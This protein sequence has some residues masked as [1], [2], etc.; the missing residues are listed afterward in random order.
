MID[1]DILKEAGTTNERLK[2]LFTAKLPGLRKLNKLTPEKRK[3]LE[4][5]IE[6]RKKFEEQLASWIQ[7][8][9]VF[10][11]KNHSLYS[12]VD[13][14]WDSVLN[15]HI[16]PL[17]L[18][19]QGR[20][21]VKA[22][23]TGLKDLPEGNTYVR[24]NEKGDVVGIDLPKFFDVRI[25]LIR[26][27]ITRRLAAQSN[28]FNNLWPFL[29]YESRSTGLVGRIKADAVSQRVDIMADQYGFRHLQ[30][31]MTRDMFL[32]GHSVALPR[33]AWEREVQWEKI[34]SAE[35]VRSA[36]GKIPKRS[37]VI[38]EGVCPVN[39]HPSRIG[40]DN[41]YPLSSL[42]TDTGCE[43]VFFWDVKRFKDIECEK[44][45]FNR[46][47][48]AFSADTAGWFSTYSTY[49]NQYYDTITPPSIPKDPAQD[50]DRKTN[51]GLYTGEM[52]DSAVFVTEFYVKVRPDKWR[53][54][55]YPFPIWLHLTV[56]GDATVINAEIMPSSPAFVF[57]FNENDSRLTNISVAH[58]LMAYQDQLTNLFTQFLEA[59]KADMFAVAVLNEDVFGDT[60]EGQKVLNEFKAI[61][62][63]KNYYSSMQVLTASFAKLAQVGVNVS[64][65]NIFK[66]VRSTPNTAI[67]KIFQSITEVIAMAERLMAL[68]PQEQGQ[69][70]PRE[71]SAT[72]TNALTNTTDSVYS[73]I[74]EP[75]D[76]GRAAWKR[77]CYESLVAMG[78]DSV[79]LPILNRYP[80]SAIERAGFKVV[81]KDE[82]EPTQLSV[83]VT[84][85]KTALI[86]DYIFTSRDGGERASNAQ[87]AQVLVELL[88]AIGQ[89][90]PEVQ[91]AILKSMGKSK[92]LDIINE[93]FR[94]ADAGLDLNLEL[95]PGDDDNLLM[96]DDQQV[97]G[98]I[99]RLGQAL[100]KES[101]R[102][103]AL[104]QAVMEMK[105]LLTGAPPQEAAA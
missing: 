21:D 24:K 9:V 1:L 89:F 93:I 88:R 45:Y 79:Y 67:D 92:V 61:M 72:E 84:G 15:K 87:Q 78:S 12:A 43:H 55:S 76:E 81:G 60:D 80:D 104:E 33:T 34:P 86:H 27:I 101:E 4:K 50:N 2:E 99:N 17:V 56:A 62:S 39:P 6:T 49:F 26:S 85:S 83:N 22:C 48:I 53:M 102:T 30:T 77:I 73:F 57:S 71:I 38:R 37:R 44:S 91:K 63:G 35:G 51:V 82:E 105:Q 25:N 19:A 46:D 36:D 70:A 66:I 74:S 20:I 75:I 13:L 42:N 28:K 96:E 10:S 18:Y 40:Y 23:A 5:D 90:Q 32:Y 3:D 103:A 95:Q 8:Q 7:E 41:S 47:G 94:K 65:D 68:S 52:G 16:L 58:E 59:A 100:G 97:M 31:Q 29:K 64:A 98:I 11:L 69:P 14:A 54:G